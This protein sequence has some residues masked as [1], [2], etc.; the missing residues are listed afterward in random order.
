MTLSELAFDLIQT[1]C[2]C[3]QIDIPID[4]KLSEGD[5]RDFIRNIISEVHKDF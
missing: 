4:A 5:F 1:W 3:L 2:Y